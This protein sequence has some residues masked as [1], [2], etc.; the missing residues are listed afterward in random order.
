MKL[1]DWDESLCQAYANGLRPMVSFDHGQWAAKIA[2]RLGDLPPGSTVLDVATGPGFLVLEIGKRL[3]DTRLVG[4]D[5][6]VPAAGRPTRPPD[7][8]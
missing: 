8:E 1:Y 4:Q 6:A 2:R 5:Q 7:P 3:P